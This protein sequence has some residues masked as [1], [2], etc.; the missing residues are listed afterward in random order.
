MQFEKTVA[1][2]VWHALHGGDLFDSEILLARPRVDLRQVNGEVRAG[3]SILG[4]GPQFT[5]ATALALRLFLPPETGIDHAQQAQ[6]GGVV[7]LLP[8]DLFHF[9][10]RGRKSGLRFS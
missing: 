1:E 3:N 5:G 4:N 2:L 7:W 10:A 8:H 6:S 9:T